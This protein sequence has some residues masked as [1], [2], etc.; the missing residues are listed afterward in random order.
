MN[1]KKAQ[2]GIRKGKRQV[3]KG[4][5]GRN[6][7]SFYENP[8]TGA[9]MLVEKDIEKKTKESP[10]RVYKHKYITTS[11]GQRKEVMSLKEKG[12]LLKKE[13]INV[14]K[15]AL[16]KQKKGGKTMMLKRKDGSVSQRGLWDNIRAAAKRNK[17]AGKPGKKPTAAMLTQERRIKAKSKKK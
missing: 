11:D 10:R 5:G 6:V 15:D 16:E 8:F 7:T 14:P 4:P 3:I 17:A 1:T 2:W 13:T 9:S 12:K